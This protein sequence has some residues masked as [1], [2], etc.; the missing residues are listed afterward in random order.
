LLSVQR[1]QGFL[2][3]GGKVQQLQQT[4]SQVGKSNRANWYGIAD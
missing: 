1:S 2:E 4:C 3:P